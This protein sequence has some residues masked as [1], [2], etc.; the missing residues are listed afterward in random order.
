LTA[1][2]THRLGLT[3]ETDEYERVRAYARHVGRPVA[4]AAKRLLLSVIDGD[5]PD[6]A[7]VA[8]SRERDR[9]RQLEDEVT[10]LQAQLPQG[11]PAADPEARLPR[12]RWPLETLVADRPWWDEWLPVLGE[13]IGRNLEY[14]RGYSDRQAR[15]V[16]DD[17]GFA[18]LMAYLFPAFTD[19][20]G[21]PVPWHSH[22][23]P[24]LARM[25]WTNAS[26]GS[27]V[28]QRPVR[29]EVWEPVV[30]H[31]ACALTALESTSRT[32]G[33]AY[34]HLRVQAEIR[35]E[36]MRTLG[37]MIGTGISQR[38]DHLPRDPLP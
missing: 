26:D 6:A 28:R 31:V 33:D 9:V 38:S 20:R 21:Q 27:R 13:L 2:A 15:P 14:D 4:T 1:A 8:L 32:S 12:W 22:E 23:Y 34:T 25:A 36:W 17:R 16:V 10:R 24:R 35:G 37:T 7:A 19:E 11:Q 29:A 18:D 3:L 30:R 5:D